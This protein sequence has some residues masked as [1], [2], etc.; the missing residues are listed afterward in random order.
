[1]LSSPDTRVGT[2]TI[3]SS[4]L[5]VAP[6]V[7]KPASVIG[8]GVP[9]ASDAVRSLAAAKKPI[10]FPSGAKK[11]WRAPSLPGITLD[12]KRSSGLT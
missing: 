2:N 1:M 11:G 6:N 5:Q 9:P 4:S 8:V 3:V 12:S 10:R 7:W